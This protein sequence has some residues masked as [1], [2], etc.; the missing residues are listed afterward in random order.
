M[1]DIAIGQPCDWILYSNDEHIL[2]T[3]FN[4]IIPTV[5]LLQQ[6]FISVYIPLGQISH[7][8]NKQC[9]SIILF[10]GVSSLQ[11]KLATVQSCK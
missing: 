1:P 2:D 3:F 4:I 6:Q 8:W 10:F 9:W 5:Y 11:F 7:Y